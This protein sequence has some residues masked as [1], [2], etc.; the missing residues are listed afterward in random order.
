MEKS[1]A[2]NALFVLIVTLSLF[3]FLPAQQPG[4]PNNWCREGLFTRESQKFGAGFVRSSK[5]AFYSDDADSC[6]TSRKC[7]TAAYAVTGDAVITS[8]TFGSFTCGWFTSSKGR[9]TVGWLRTAD[10]DFP[11]MP[12][13]ESDRVL[14]GIWN[15]ARI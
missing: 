7:K 9:V 11:L 10:L 3:S 4:N 6:P 2:K 14:T 13:D 8:R 12:Y 5:A 1:S 15:T